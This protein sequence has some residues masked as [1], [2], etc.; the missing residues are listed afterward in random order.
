MY[1]LYNNH[2]WARWKAESLFYHRNVCFL[3]KLISFFLVVYFIVQTTCTYH[4]ISWRQSL[5]FVDWI[6][7]KMFANK[8]IHMQNV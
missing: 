4:F 6:C 1:V 8:L 7:P 3:F 5:T 2:K